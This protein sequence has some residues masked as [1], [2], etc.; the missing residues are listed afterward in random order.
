M[1]PTFGVHTGPS[2]T[3]VDELTA[4]W[5]RIESGPFDWI[6]IWD[7]LYGADGVSHS[8]LD[9]VALH[10]ALALKTTRV[11]CGALV[12]CAA[13]RHPAVL[14]KAMTTID[15][16]SGG[17]CDFG[18]GAGWARYEYEAF[19]IRYPKPSERLDVLDESIQCVRGLLHQSDGDVFDFDGA[20]FSMKEAVNLPRPVQQRLPIWIGGGG[21]KRTLRIAAL[22]AD[23]WNV[24]FVSPET[25]AHKNRVLDEHCGSVGRDP[26]EIRRS[27]NVGCAPDEASLLRQFGSIAEIARPGVLVGSREQIL[28]GIGRY[29]GAGAEQINLAMRAPFEY[30]MLDLMAE[31]VEGW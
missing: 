26:S 21:E 27:I 4:L 20:H 12:Y 10:T 9:A 14:A 13:Y 1:K 24:P 19:G 3:T 17:R 25:F 31:A 15:L 16:L 22:H 5:A 2:N 23:G 30:D 6:S 7:H 8:N 11:R 28:D 29:V 18:L